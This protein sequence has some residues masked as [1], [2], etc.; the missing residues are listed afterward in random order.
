MRAS[1]EEE[2]QSRKTKK[3][4]VKEAA[5]AFKRRHLRSTVQDY[6][7]QLSSSLSILSTPIDTV[8]SNRGLYYLC[9]KHDR[10]YNGDS[11][12]S[13]VI[14]LLANLRWRRKSTVSLTWLMMST[15][16]MPFLDSRDFE[17]LPG[18]RPLYRGFNYEYYYLSFKS[19][20]L[21]DCLIRDNI[22]LCLR[23]RVSGFNIPSSRPLSYSTRHPIMVRDSSLVG[24]ESRSQKSSGSRST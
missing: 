5:K 20:L 24:F 2:L 8:S 1:F 15:V 21:S 6:R 18:R 17:N 7:S 12:G 19:P 16:A 23:L 11:S 14:I 4:M 22:A 10:A 9:F 13:G 3:D